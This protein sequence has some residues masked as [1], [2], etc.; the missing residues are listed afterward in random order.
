MVADHAQPVHLRLGKFLAGALI[1]SNF[2]VAYA[3]KPLH[4]PLGH[5]GA[6]GTSDVTSRL[7][8][9]AIAGKLGHDCVVAGDGS[10][11]GS[12]AA[13]RRRH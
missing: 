12:V 1:E 7:V 4:V 11:R 8:L 9:K 6:N 3:Y 10:S 2:D 5:F 13:N